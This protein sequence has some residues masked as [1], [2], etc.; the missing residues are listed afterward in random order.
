MVDEG[1]RRTTTAPL[2][3]DESEEGARG[4]FAEEL[5]EGANE[6]FVSVSMDTD[7]FPKTL[8]FTS[9]VD[10]S[11]LRNT[12]ERSV[13]RG[14]TSF[15]LLSV[16]TNTAEESCD[17]RG[18]PLLGLVNGCRDGEVE[19]DDADT[20]ERRRSRAT[21]MSSSRSRSNDAGDTDWRGFR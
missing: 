2:V 18:P 4:P 13:R 17:V 9:F 21:A 5:L 20:R 12:V 1:G 15:A 8:G 6:D 3:V 11:A 7:V 19:D 14:F 16:F 10:T